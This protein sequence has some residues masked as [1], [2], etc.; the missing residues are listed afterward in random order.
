MVGGRQA[1][2]AVQVHAVFALLPELDLAEV[3]DH[4]GQQV[5]AR[6]ADFIQQ[7]LGDAQFADQ[8]AGALDLADG[9]L[10]V[11]TDLHNRETDVFVVRHLPP[12]G[13]V[14]AGALRAAFDDMPGQCRLGQAVVVLPGPV[15]LMHQRRADHRAVHHTAGYHDI[16]T[17]LQRL[18]DAGRAEVGV[19]GYAHRRQGRAA[20]HVGDAVQLL[21]LRLQVIPQQ[22]GDLQRDSGLVAGR[23]QRGGAG[24]GVDPAGVADHADALAL[25]IR[26]QRRQHLDEIRG[27]AGLGIFHSRSG[28]DRQGDFRQVVEHQVIQR[29]AVHQLRSGGAG[30]A[31]EGAGA[32]DAYRLVH[33]ASFLWFAGIHTTKQALGL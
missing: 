23:L 15:E 33:G 8:S 3:A 32:A 21:E 13:E 6:V 25:D 22:Y 14:A 12:I 9:E 5:G 4:V 7:L 27:I 30:V 11:G 28:E 1:F 16:G 26:Q 31:P 24:L 19:G 29:A 20:E 2:G 17:Q 18:H 10:A